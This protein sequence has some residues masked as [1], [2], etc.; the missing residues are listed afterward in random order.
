MKK[1]TRRT[2]PV[3]KC[4]RCGHKRA[5]AQSTTELGVYLVQEH[6]RAG[7]DRPCKG[8]NERVSAK[9]VQW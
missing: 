2:T 8:S 1:T 4:P 7:Y 9:A 5:V 6:R 3:A